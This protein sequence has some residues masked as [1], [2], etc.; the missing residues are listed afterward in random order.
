MKPLSIIFQD[1][2]DS[3][4][5]YSVGFFHRRRFCLKV[6]VVP[7][8]LKQRLGYGLTV[9][10]FIF[11]GLTGASVVHAQ[12][13]PPDIN[14]DNISVQGSTQ[15]VVIFEPSRIFPETDTL[16]AGISYLGVKIQLEENTPFDLELD[17]HARLQSEDIDELGVIHPIVRAGTRETFFYFGPTHLNGV[18]RWILEIWPSGSKSGGNPSTSVPIQQAM[19]GVSCAKVSSNP[20]PIEAVVKTAVTV[21]MSFAPD[22]VI[23]STIS[24]V[25][26]PASIYLE[27]DAVERLWE[28]HSLGRSGRHIDLILE[29]YKT[30]DDGKIDMETSTSKT[31]STTVSNISTTSVV[32][33]LL[34]GLPSA[35]RWMIEVKDSTNTAVTE[36]SKSFPPHRIHATIPSIVIE[37]EEIPVDLIFGIMDEA[38]QTLSMNF[39]YRRTTEHRVVAFDEI[40]ILALLRDGVVLGGN[41]TVTAIFEVTQDG[42][43]EQ[44]QLMDFIPGYRGAVRTFFLPGI[45]TWNFL[46]KEVEPR[47]ILAYGNSTTL[48]VDPISI[49]IKLHPPLYLGIPFTITV[50]TNVQ[51]RLGLDIPVL[52]KAELRDVEGSCVGGCEKRVVIPKGSKSTTVEYTLLTFGRWHFEVSA[53][54][55]SLYGDSSGAGGAG[56]AS[57]ESDT[58]DTTKTDTWLRIEPAYF[59]DIEVKG[60]ATS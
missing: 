1:I 60:D 49:S 16:Y 27:I 9:L 23:G 58:S 12:L 7:V 52:V 43:N 47:G 29:M 3:A 5:K 44:D 25:F 6:P 54:S 15:C 53:D 2:A 18:G 10:L 36:A 11:V 51:N 14:S 22:T 46:L 33:P 31:F 57:G 59:S 32:I 21:V 42:K 39:G 50:G 48:T 40:S 56:G 8:H 13:L 30:L 34:G 4:E 55:T 35:G 45:G 41:T 20:E 17:M 38:T 24:Y 28:L 19:T 26:K 37:V